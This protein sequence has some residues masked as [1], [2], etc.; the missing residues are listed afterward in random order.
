MFRLYDRIY[1]IW[2]CEVVVTS[3]GGWA[4][5]FGQQVMLMSGGDTLR[6]VR[7]RKL[8][9]GFNPSSQRYM[10]HWMKR[11][12]K[13][14]KVEQSE[15]YNAYDLACCYCD[16][17]TLK[18]SLWTALSWGREIVLWPHRS[19]TQ[20]VLSKLS[21]YHQSTSVENQSSPN[22]GRDRNQPNL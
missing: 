21:F 15:S 1:R 6:M 13:L 16:W 4:R 17:D 10:I 22:R 9:L 14:T 2:I 20:S 7:H 5:S 8:L 18:R 19:C 12:N 11:Y 3:V